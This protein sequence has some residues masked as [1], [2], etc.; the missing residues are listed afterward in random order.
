MSQASVLIIATQYDAP[1]YY[2][3][4]WAEDL[5]EDLA[6]RGHTCLLL[7][8]SALCRSGTSLGDAIKC[9]EVVVFYGHGLADQWI[10]LPDQVNPSG[11][12][13]P[14]VDAAAT[15]QM[16][17]DRKVYALC[18]HS[19]AGVG[20]AYAKLSSAPGYVGYNNLFGFDT[21]NHE[22]FREVVNQSVIAFVKGDS[23]QDVEA[24]LKASWEDLRDS[25][26]SGLLKHRPNGFAA[27]QVADDN[28]QY[29]GK[30][31]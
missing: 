14:I 9:A 8:G 6:T 7:D 15:Y 21:A 27:S 29:V 1:S 18:C 16:L 12:T 3:Y 24:L 5:Q 10:G 22:Y 17:N 26:G 30:L 28:R 2:T 4:R 23:A 13:I 31:P 11:P 25:F 19:L 20:A